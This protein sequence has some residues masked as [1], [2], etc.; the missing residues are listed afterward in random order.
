MNPTLH[1]EADAEFL[2]AVRHYAE[3]SPDLGGRFYDEVVALLNEACHHPQRYR[4]FEAPVRR[5]LGTV[6]PYG[7]LYVAQSDRVWI[8]AIMHLKRRPGYWKH[9]LMD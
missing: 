4:L 6:F 5:I 1:P 8:V 2:E 9:R 7:V 3:I